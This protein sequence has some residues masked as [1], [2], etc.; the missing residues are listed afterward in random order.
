MTTEEFIQRAREVHGDKYDYSK[1]EYVDCKTKVLIICPK[2]GKFTQ[3]PEAH[4]RMGHGCPLCGREK[5]V[6]SR[7]L[8]YKENIIIEAQKY[9]TQVEFKHGS[10]GAY[11]AAQRLG[12]LKYLHQ[13]WQKDTKPRGY[14][15]IE[16]CKEVAQTCVN[17]SDLLKKYPRAYKL[18]SDNNLLDVF[19]V[20]EKDKNAEIHCVYRYFFPQTN[21]IYIGRTL[22]RRIEKRDYEHKTSK[23]SSVLKYSNEKNLPIPDIEVL[24]D[25]LTCSE[26]LIKENELVEVAR[27]N[28]LLVLNVAKTG[29]VS[30]S[31]GAIG[32]GHL[33][34]GFCYEIAKTCKTRTEFQDKNPSAYLKANKMGWSK[35]YTW[36]EEVHKPKGYWDVYENCYAEFVKCGSSLE[37]LRKEK[38]TCYCRAAKNGFTKNWQKKRVAHNKKWTYETLSE[39]VKK[40]PRQTELQ[41]HESGAYNALRK[42]GLLYEFY[43]RQNDKPFG[44]WNI[45]ENVE[46]EAKK[47]KSRWDFG[48]N[49]GSAYDAALR[50]KWIDILF[51]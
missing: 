47:Y 6:N 30:G 48:K 7:K 20:N 41:K 32:F 12:M 24:F 50:N 40:Y 38:Y 25:N 44:Y 28:G 10:G 11:C 17:R 3:R 45:F 8:W 26:S 35:D 29:S 18:L 1:V 5:T 46:K 2:H 16:K 34:Y 37:R 27:Q 36:F 49:N 9:N 39:I 31:A 22:N 51:P 23:T 4:Y 13:F 14:W 43:P 42:M 33:S 19:F 21:A 15:T